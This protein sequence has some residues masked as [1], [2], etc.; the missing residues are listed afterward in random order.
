[1]AAVQRQFGNAL[2]I[3]HGSDRSVFGLQ[4][5]GGG[6]NFDRFGDFADLQK[7]IQPDR[8]LHLQLQAIA[9]CALEARVFGSEVVGPGG[10]EGNA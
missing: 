1:L 2:V 3:D 9:G 7:Q 5:V 6:R 4:Q 8:L 10:A